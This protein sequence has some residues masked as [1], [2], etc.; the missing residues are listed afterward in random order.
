M[1]RYEDVRWAPPGIGDRRA[2]G[3]HR[4]L[5]EKAFSSLQQAILTGELKPGER[6]PI[7]EV[8]AS[9][10]MSPM[11]VREA[12]RRLDLL[13]L[14]QNVPHKGATVTELSTEDLNE[15]YELRLMLEP[16]AVY[17]AAAVFKEADR[18][19]AQTTLDVM[20]AARD[21]SADVWRAH[22]AFHLGLYAVAGSSWLM[23]LIQPLWESNERYRFAIAA[24]SKVIHRR[25]EHE[26]LLQAC[27]DHDPS[28]AAYELYNHLATTANAEAKVM[29]G[30]HLF[31]VLEGGAWQPVPLSVP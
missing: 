11:P 5:A 9:L 2:P 21:G 10:G 18:E 23:R 3:E 17:R 22:S 29:G 15:I 28:R 12:V 8:A 1:A 20:N 27:V 31:A 16:L 7:E 13:G 4:T 14:V 6:L 19:L 25:Y 26:H 30:G 24:K